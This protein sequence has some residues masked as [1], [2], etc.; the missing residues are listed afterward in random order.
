MGCEKMIEEW[1]PIINTDYEVSNIGNIKNSRTNR[2]KKSGLSSNGYLIFGAFKGCQRTNI[3]VHRAVVEAFIGKIPESKEVNHK[4]GNKQNNIIDNL[5]VV[6]KSENANHAIKNGLW[7]LTN[8]QNS[9]RYSG[10]EHWTHKH[11]ELTAKG[12]NNGARTHPE[13]ILKGEQCPS[14]KLTYTDVID[15]KYQYFG[16]ITINVLAEIYKV[17]Y[18]TIW[19]VVNNRTWK[20]IL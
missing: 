12:N 7:D 2:I 1:K 17:T 13:R 18:R 19:Y 10:E 8:L 9:K 15:I 20:G 14:S 5:E 3:L 6:S 11:P 16:G 4:D